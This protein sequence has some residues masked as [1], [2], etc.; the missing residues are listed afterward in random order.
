[1]PIP[2]R[3]KHLPRRE[4]R[5]GLSWAPPGRYHHITVHPATDSP[6]DRP[7]GLSVRASLGF[8]GLKPAPPFDRP[9]GLSYYT[10]NADPVLASASTLSSNSKP[11]VRG[12]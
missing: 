5:T 6:W 12:L 11:A 10:L 2:R 9:G 1:M 8:G 4:Y 3:G 7:P